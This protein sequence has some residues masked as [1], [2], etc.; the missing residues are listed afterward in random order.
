MIAISVI[1]PNYNHGLYLKERIDSVLHQTYTNYEIIILD[2][3]STDNSREIIEGYCHKRISHITYNDKNS[4]SPFKQWQKGIKLAK[5]DWIWIAESDDI[6]EPNFLS[7]AVSAIEMEQSIGLFYCDA[8]FKNDMENEVSTFSMIKNEYFDTNKWSSNYIITGL[9]E[10]TEG[11][12]I[13]CTINNASST[14]MRKDLLLQ[15]IDE[16]AE[17]RFH[18]DWF[19]YLA[20][21]SKSNIAYTASVLNF[22]R[23]DSS[24]IKLFLPE[25]GK[26]RTE[27]FAILNHI[28]N[29]FHPKLSYKQL[30]EFTLLNLNIKLTSN[31]KTI[32]SYIRINKI[33]AWKVIFILFKSRFR[34]IQFL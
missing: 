1:I 21:A 9:K 29:Q 13:R 33:L 30:Q 4:G 27:C 22:H 12:G 20:I 7:S 31:F 24:N 25:D 19:C 6:A 23:T 26:H 3:C 16:A 34:K 15:Y 5:F 32:L 10:I 17:Y 14:L 2:D 18:G 28:N 8:R 11:L